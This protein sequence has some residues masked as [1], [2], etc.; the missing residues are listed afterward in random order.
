MTVFRTCSQSTK[1]MHSHI[2]WV[3]RGA[4]ETKKT[5]SKDGLHACQLN[6]RNCPKIESIGRDWCTNIPWSS[7]LSHDEE[8]KQVLPNRKISEIH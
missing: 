5:I 6:A 7:I 3:C 2:I 1:S 8:N 4:R